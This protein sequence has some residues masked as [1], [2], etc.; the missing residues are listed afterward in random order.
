MT[1]QGDRALPTGWM[2]VLVQAWA[3]AG[4][5][6]EVR[7]L[8]G[9]LVYAN[10]AWSA[11]EDGLDGEPTT[12]WPTSV[13]PALRDGA[14]ADGQ[15]SGLV[16]VVGPDGA[17]RHLETRALRVPAN[18]QAPELL[19]IVRRDVTTGLRMAESLSDHELRLELTSLGARDALW[20]WKID[21]DEAWFSSRWFEILGHP[22]AAAEARLETWLER[23]HADDRQRLEEAIDE[24]LAGQSPL[25][26][27]EHRV[28]HAS[29]TWTWFLV[30]G[31]V[32][33]RA[34]G[35]AAAPGRLLH[36]SHRDQER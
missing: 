30:R 22:A 31:R 6:V 2:H 16:T 19:V 36:R 27:V 10:A 14:S 23:V 24:H 35:R 17:S 25:L 33:Q 34:G 1:S 12:G 4:E 9:T 8:D 20:D 3:A 11:V 18:D 5:S 28:Q 21:R 13:P 15:W 26:E 7:R 32:Q 29:G